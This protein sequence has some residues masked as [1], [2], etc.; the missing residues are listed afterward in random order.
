MPSSSHRA[1]SPAPIALV[2]GLILS[3]TLLLSWSAAAQPC[4]NPASLPAIEAASA[5]HADFVPPT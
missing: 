3:L 4:G 1:D 5:V 2:V